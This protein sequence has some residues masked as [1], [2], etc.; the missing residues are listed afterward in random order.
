MSRRTRGL[1]QSGRC[2]APWPADL[3]GS[4]LFGYS[5]AVQARYDNRLRNCR[6]GGLW[7]RACLLDSRQCAKRSD[8]PEEM[9]LTA[10]SSFAL[11]FV[12]LHWLEPVKAG[13]SAPTST[14]LTGS[15]PMPKIPGREGEGS[16]SAE[17]LSAARLL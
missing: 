15:D 14:A 12:I 6:C 17:S 13:T 16:N 8:R 10:R 3:I 4:S 9:Y 2:T 5:V 1:L 11:R 7:R